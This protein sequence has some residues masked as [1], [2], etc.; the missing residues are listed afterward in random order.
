MFLVIHAVGWE[1]VD[2]GRNGE[3][4]VAGDAVDGLLDL[5]G[6][7]AVLDVVEDHVVDEDAL[8]G[9]AAFGVEQAGV[10]AGE[11]HSGLNGTAGVGPG[12]LAGEG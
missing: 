3:C 4:G 6:V 9:R 7:E 5:E 1:G 12:G 2:A 8:D 10:D 11:D